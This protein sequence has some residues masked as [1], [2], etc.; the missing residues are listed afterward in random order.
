[1]RLSAAGRVGLVGVLL[2][3]LWALVYAVLG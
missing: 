2:C 3:G 1:L